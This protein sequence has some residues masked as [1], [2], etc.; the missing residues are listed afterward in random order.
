MTL[1]ENLLNLYRVDSQVRGLR[2]RLD[3]AKRYLAA[4]TKLYEELSEQLAESRSRRKQHQATAANLEAEGQGLDER[5]EKLRGEL[6]SAATTKQYNAL[7]SEL[8]NIK[9]ERSKVD[10]RLLAE[11]EQIEQAE[12][13]AKEIEAQLEERGK[14]RDHAAAQL[15]ERKADVGQRLTELEN[16]REQATVSIPAKELEIFDRLAETYDGEAM[17]PV[18]EISRRHREYACGE[19]NMHMPY[20]QVSILRSATDTIVQCPACGRILYMQDEMRESLAAKKS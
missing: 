15:E 6:N 8:T 10:D 12:A 7:L 11:M 3:V 2:N 17:A 4:Q 9:A 1:M 14:V 5:I 20:E 16:E 18:E 19:C 13:R